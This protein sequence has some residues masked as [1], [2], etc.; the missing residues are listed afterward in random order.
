[1]CAGP[2]FREVLVERIQAIA[3]ADKGEAHA[4]LL[5][6]RPIYHSLVFGDVDARDRRVILGAGGERGGIGSL[7]SAAERRTPHDKQAA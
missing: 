6:R 4:C 2:V 5:D 7:S 3:D 1:M